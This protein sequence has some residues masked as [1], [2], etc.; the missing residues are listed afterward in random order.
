MWASIPIAVVA[1][2]L[3]AVPPTSQHAKRM[4][5]RAEGKNVVV[6]FLD[7]LRYDQSGVAEQGSSWAPNLHAFSKD[8]LNFDWAFASAS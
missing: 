2:A 5:R 6:I 4:R 8:S 7:T 1:L 3:L